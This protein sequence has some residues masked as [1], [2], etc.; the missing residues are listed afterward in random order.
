MIRQGLQIVG[1][2]AGA[3]GAALALAFAAQHVVVLE[4]QK[5]KPLPEVPVTVSFGTGAL[6]GD[7]GGDYV[8]GVENVLAVVY[9]SGNVGLNTQA[10][11]R[12]LATRKVC[13]SFG[14]QQVPQELAAALAL[15]SRVSIGHSAGPYVAPGRIPIQSMADGQVIDASG[16][17]SWKVAGAQ[18]GTTIQ[19]RLWYGWDVTGDG[20]IDS[21]PL[22]VTCIEGG[23]SQGSCT[24]WTVATEANSGDLWPD[25]TATLQSSVVTVK[26]GKVTTGPVVQL[27]EFVMPF[28]MTV[29]RPV[30]V[31]P[32]S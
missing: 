5:G 21:P 6:Q 29:T 3:L 11:T 15:D 26:G 25:H 13:L 19:Y 8:N 12:Q 4:A 27:G 1:T 10:D 24:M 7:L 17:F 2:A 22:K 16:W 31:E 30:A 9:P 18:A 28:V 23:S 20:N 32:Q 14:A